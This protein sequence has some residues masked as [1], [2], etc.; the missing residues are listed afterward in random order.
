M[1][2]YIPNLTKSSS[3]KEKNLKL[4]SKERKNSK[5]SHIQQ[6]PSFQKKEKIEN[7]K[8]EDSI[9]ISVDSMKL[10]EDEDEDDRQLKEDKKIINKEKAKILNL[11]SKNK[12]KNKNRLINEYFQTKIKK[13]KKKEIEKNKTFLNK[14]ISK[15]KSEE[16]HII[17]KEENLINQLLKLYSFD[18]IFRKCLQENLDTEKNLDNFI[19]NLVNTLGY[20]K[21]FKI[22]LAKF[23]L[24]S[25]TKI[26]NDE[27]KNKPNDNEYIND[28]PINNSII[29]IMDIKVN[30]FRPNHNNISKNN[31]GLGLHLQKNE[32]G[33]IYKY[34]LHRVNNCNAWFNCSN[35]NCRGLASLELKNKEFKVKREHTIKYKF[36]TVSSKIIPNEI[37]LFDYFKKID[38]N[39][40]QIIY[41]YAGDAYAVFY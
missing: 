25:S 28:F 22:L 2:D 32:N 27:K 30:K 41:R 8:I 11:K 33:E 15:S 20:E 24:F 5:S 16:N 17:S 23:G 34:I 13:D 38:K 12:Y 21:L 9:D 37:P 10:D 35:K 36:H 18:I 39:D 6:K 29:K 3:L 31:R 4:P 14:K 26:N 19:I 40:V 1:D 7:R